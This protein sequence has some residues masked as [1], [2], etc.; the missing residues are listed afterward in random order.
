MKTLPKKRKILPSTGGALRQFDKCRA[1]EQKISLRT[2]K[3]QHPAPIVVRAS[4]AHRVTSPVLRFNA[5]TL[6]R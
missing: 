4:T 2:G 3:D 5:S 1:C 6:G